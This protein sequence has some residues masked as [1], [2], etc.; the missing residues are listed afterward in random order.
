[1]HHI[2]RAKGTVFASLIFL[3]LSILW[4]FNG[5]IIF[6]MFRSNLSSQ[7]KYQELY[8]GAE[9]LVP[10]LILRGNDF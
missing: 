7:E 4:V 5:K 6:Y 3:S 2:S 9:Y 10:T 1:M 8:L